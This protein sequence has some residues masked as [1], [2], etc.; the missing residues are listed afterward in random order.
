VVS[1]NF[2]SAAGVV[3]FSV[4]EVDLVFFRC[5][6]EIVGDELFAVVK[7]DLLGGSAFSECLVEGCVSLLSFLCGGMP[8]IQRGIVSSHRQ[9]R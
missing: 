9:S 6:F 8:W 1:F 4:D 2:S 5:L 7:V 3:G